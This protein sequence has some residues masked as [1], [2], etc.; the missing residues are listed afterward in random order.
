MRYAAFITTFQ[1]PEI[2]ANTVHKLLEQT[3]RPEKIL[4]IDNDP[5]ESAKGVVEMLQDADISYYGVGENQGP[6]GGAHQGLKILFEEGW[7]WVLWVDDDDPPFFENVIENLLSSAIYSKDDSIGMIGAVG[8][9]FSHWNSTIQRI[10]STEL[11]GLVEVDMVGGGQFPLIHRRCYDAGVLPDSSLFFGF[12]DLEYCIRLKK[13][14]FKLVVNGDEMLRHRTLH[15]RLNFKIPFYAVKHEKFLW[16]EYYS[17]RTLSH[18]QFRVNFNYLYLFILALKILV[19]SVIGF[20]NSWTYGWKNSFYL[21]VGF[22][23]GIT[24]KMGNIV[25]PVKKYSLQNQ[26]HQRYLPSFSYAAFIITYQRPDQLTE[27]IKQLLSQTLP[28][29][30]ILIVDNDPMCSASTVCKLFVDKC[31]QYY[32]TGYN[33]GPSGGA[34]TGISEL[35]K[36]NYEWV[37]WVDDDD[38]PVFSN[39][40]E[41]LGKTA[42]AAKETFNVGV[43]GSTGAYFNAKTA[44]TCRPADSLLENIFEVDW[45]AGNQFPLIHR[46]VFEAML[47]PNPDLFFGFEDLEFCLRVKQAGFSIVIEGSEA[48]RLR[49][50]FKRMK[51]QRSILKQKEYDLL[52]RDYYSTRT[53]FYILFHMQPSFIGRNM[54]FIRCSIKIAAGFFKGLRHGLEN[55]NLLSNAYSDGK[56]HKL[57]LTILPAKK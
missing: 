53:L 38:P 24:G 11:K 44:R 31:I 8:V 7:E 25:R 52:W 21:L 35:F 3:L 47:L 36:Q 2:L 57:G 41:N 20:S 10:P 27:T 26:T 40:F 5:H 30:K 22:W 46:K 49:Q 6:A 15:K 28:P 45:V 29:S 55:M 33:A 17:I 12:E 32:S 1:R 39:Q 54:L 19:K 50:Y 51:R 48:Y 43:V 16:R 9:R 23:H 4:I 18:I 34:F 42:F 13:A 14:G 56:K 37:A